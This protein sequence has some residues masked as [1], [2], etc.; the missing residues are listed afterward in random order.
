MLSEFLSYGFG[1]PPS[2]G[3][4]CKFL[5]DGFGRWSNGTWKPQVEG[6]AGRFTNIQQGDQT[7]GIRFRKLHSFL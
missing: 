5:W 1:N 4:D 2:C 3:E 6:N 7:R